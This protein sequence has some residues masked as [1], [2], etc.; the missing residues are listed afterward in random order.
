MFSNKFSNCF[1]VRGNGNEIRLRWCEEREKESCTKLQSK[2][3]SF[4]EGACWNV[5]EGYA[6]EQVQSGVPRKE[7]VENLQ[8]QD[9][10]ASQE[11]RFAGHAL[12]F[13]LQVRP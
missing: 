1:F 2:S 4:P 12:Q 3:A 11:G 5:P 10:G 6:T 8:E 13:Q 9:N 7:G